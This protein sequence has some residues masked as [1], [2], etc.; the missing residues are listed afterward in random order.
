MKLRTALIIALSAAA[1]AAGDAGARSRTVTDPDAPRALPEQGPVSVR[2]DDP[3]KFAEIRYSRNRYDAR[4]GNW[5]EQLAEH[6]RK[7][8]QKELPAGQRLDVDITDIKRAGDYEP[9]HGPQFDDTRFVRDIYPPRIVL[10]FK[11]TDA[12][13]RVVEEGQRTLRDLSFLMGPRPLSDSDPLR[14]EKRLIDDWLRQ[15]FK[16]PDA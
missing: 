5:V 12:D 14:Y 13:G 6:L 8:A 10:S 11:R 1:L 15:E 3:A 7:R 16:A 4:R 9:W 2:W